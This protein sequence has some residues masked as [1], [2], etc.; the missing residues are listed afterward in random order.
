[1]MNRK[2]VDRQ[3]LGVLNLGHK[4]FNADYQP[5]QYSEKNH[6]PT[7]QDTFNHRVHRLKKFIKSV[8]FFN[9]SYVLQMYITLGISFMKIQQFTLAGK[10]AGSDD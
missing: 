2:Y 5:D 1:M 4:R 7:R 3:I 10:L 6:Y 9:T 8:Y